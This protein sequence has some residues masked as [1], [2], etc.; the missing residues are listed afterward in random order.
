MDCAYFLI[1]AP[2]PLCTTKLSGGL[3]NGGLWMNQ[4]ACFKNTRPRDYYPA[5][6]TQ[7][8]FNHSYRRVDCF[9]FYT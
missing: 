4:H 6:A 8:L 3:L 5:I 2:K 9:G 7:L 1:Y